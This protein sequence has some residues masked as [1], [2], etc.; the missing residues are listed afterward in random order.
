MRVVIADDEPLQRYHLRSVIKEIDP[1][2]EI[3]E[4]VNGAELAAFVAEGK[5]DAAFV[6]VRMPKLDGLQAMKQ[7]GA[8]GLS[9][10]W[11]VMSSHSEFSYARTAME[12][13]ALAYAL[14]P[15]SVEE[16]GGLLEKLTE[17]FRRGREERVRDFELAWAVEETVE[18]KFPPIASGLLVVDDVAAL[19]ASGSVRALRQRILDR[20]RACDSGDLTAIVAGQLAGSLEIANSGPPAFWNVAYAAAPGGRTLCLV[21]E[22]ADSPR[23][24]RSRLPSLRAIASYRALIPPGVIG[25]RAAAELMAAFTSPE[26]KGAEAAGRLVN[27]AVARER[28]AFRDAAVDL[29]AVSGKLDDA[30][31]GKILRFLARALGHPFPEGSWVEALGTLRNG[32]PADFPAGVL[33]GGDGEEAGEAGDAIASVERYLRRHFA[34][35][36]SLAETASLF[37]LTPNYLSSLFHQRMGVTF[38]EFVTALRLERARGL[39]RAGKSVKETSW[40]VGYGSERHFGQLYRKRYG[41]PPTAERNAKS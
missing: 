36:V 7:A 26:L 23:D 25:V 12:L 37:S 32:A 5:A 31:R 1:A 40:A 19:A 8:A 30:V 41:I 33:F 9:V 11:V 4:A 16:V 17:A 29:E 10:P 13:G 15:P 20:S 3:L 27:A 14:K 38:V 28:V 18:D 21:A 2:I 22:T 24:A 6:D 34:D 35:R 39:L